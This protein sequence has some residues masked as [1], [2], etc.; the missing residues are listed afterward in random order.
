MK[1]QILSEEF[2]HMQKIAGIITE[3][4]ET[5]VVE[6]EKNDEW[7]LSLDTDDKN[8]I[9]YKNRPWAKKFTNEEDAIKYANS[10]SYDV[11]IE[12]PDGTVLGKNSKGGWSEVF[13]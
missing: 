4:E 5:Y 2:K 12:L 3:S 7:L 6:K 10:V 11:E 8:P 9:T 1:R 13:S